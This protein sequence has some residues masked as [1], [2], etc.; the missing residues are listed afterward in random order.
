MDK[1]KKTIIIMVIILFISSIIVAIIIY[2]INKAKTEET[3]GINEYTQV[4]EIE[5]DT[6][7][8]EEVSPTKYYAIKHVIDQY[9]ENMSKFNSNYNV[10]ISG[11]VVEEDTVLESVDAM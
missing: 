7:I 1:S 8:K 11:V 4:E 10:I 6:S 3:E 5:V 2:D 9:Y